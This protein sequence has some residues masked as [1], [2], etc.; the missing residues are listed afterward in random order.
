MDGATGD[1][2]RRRGA[3]MSRGTTFDDCG[4]RSPSAYRDETDPARRRQVHEEYLRR[5][6]PWSAPVNVEAPEIVRAV[7]EE[8]LRLGADIIISNNFWTS[9]SKLARLGVADE[10]ERYTR[11]GGELAIQSRNAVN[12]EAYV[13]GGIAPPSDEDLGQ[14]FREQARVLAEA[15]V[16]VMLPEYVGAIDE[17]VAA[18]EA[19]ATVGLPVLLGV[20]NVTDRGTMQ[21]WDSFEELARALAGAPVAAVLLMC[22]QPDSVSAS[23][24]KLREAFPG[25]IGAYAHVPKGAEYDAEAHGPARY[26]EYGHEWLAQGAQ[27]IGGCCGTGPEHIAALAPLVKSQRRPV[28]R[29]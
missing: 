22:S 8:Y 23:L 12:P 16:D 1:E 4:P 13:A 18:V 9:P 28:G 3:D 14:A 6:G 27:I 29:P 2:L 17:C 25:P 19:C 24:P 10:W 15:G 21:Y 20:R 7:H 11:V 26:A 5:L